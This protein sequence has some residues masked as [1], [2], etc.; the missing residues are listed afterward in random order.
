MTYSTGIEQEYYF[1]GGPMAKASE[2]PGKFG[3]YFFG[4]GEIFVGLLFVL[5]SLLMLFIPKMVP[6]NAQV[7][8]PNMELISLFYFAFASFVI[9]MGVGT[10]MA[11]RWA[12]KI[13]LILSWY[14]LVVGLLASVF[15]FFFM[16][17]IFG[18]SLPPSPTLTPAVIS[19]IKIGMIVALGFF[20]ILLPVLFVLFYRS[21]YV[22]RAVEYY[23]PKENWMDA[24]PTPVFAVSLF[25]V[26][27]ALCIGLLLTMLGFNFPFLGLPLPAWGSALIGLAIVIALLYIAA[28]FYH[29]EMKAWWVA[30]FLVIICCGSTY[31]TF[32]LMDPMTLYQQMHYTDAQIDQMKKMGMFTMFQ[33]MSNVWWVM[34]VPYSAYL[35]FI[36]KYFF[37]K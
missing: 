35:L 15:M 36:R 12:R 11:K 30:L 17:S 34:L 28:G 10:F 27:G 25:S 22:L 24:C 13:M 6:A 23:D 33:S 8:M 18:N 7:P 31:F 29:L 5:F 16:R 20:Y 26:F 37:K 2:K 19:G 32:K 4:L 9:A 1:Q 3:F 14:G 21:Q